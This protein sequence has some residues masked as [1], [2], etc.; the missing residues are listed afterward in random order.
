MR[1]CGITGDSEVSEA[2][3][4]R[5]IL[6]LDNSNFSGTHLE[7]GTAAAGTL[8]KI[9]LIYD[10][11]NRPK[12]IVIDPMTYFPN[13][14]EIVKKNLSEA[15][16]DSNEITF[17]KEKSSKAYKKIINSGERFDFIFIDGAHKTKQVWQD[18]RYTNMLSSGGILCIDDYLDVPEVQT[19]V[20]MFLKKNPVYKKMTIEGR[21]LFIK[22]S[23]SIKNKRAIFESCSIP[24]I[25]LFF[26]WRRSFVKRFPN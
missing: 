17:Y 9:M 26:Q 20:D 22:K 1:E 18:M 3:I 12:F 6:F 11:Q 21:T 24:F 14:F 25:N 10:K 13:Q 15:G 8:K 5:M 4:N 2:V 23:S 19:P 16:I 7:I